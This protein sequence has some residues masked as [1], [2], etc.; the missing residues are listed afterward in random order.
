[1]NNA[2]GDV[3]KT[4][5]SSKCF[6]RIGEDGATYRGCF[7]GFREI[8]QLSYEYNGC[9]N[10]TWNNKALRWCFCDSDL[11]NG[12]SLAEMDTKRGYKEYD[13]N[14]VD[15]YYPEDKQDYDQYYKREEESRYVAPKT[16]NMNKFAKMAPSGSQGEP[17]E[18]VVETNYGFDVAHDIAPPQQYQAVRTPPKQY[19]PEY[20]T[21]YVPEQNSYQQVEETNPY[22]DPRFRERPTFYVEEK[23]PEPGYYQQHYSS[24]YDQQQPETVQGTRYYEEEDRSPPTYY[25]EERRPNHYYTE[26]TRPSINDEGVY[27]QNYAEEPHQY[28]P[29]AREGPENDLFIDENDP[30]YP[31]EPIYAEKNDYDTP[32]AAAQTS[33]NEEESYMPYKTDAPEY[34][35]E[36][37]QDP[38]TEAPSTVT[39]KVQKVSP[40]LASQ[41]SCDKTGYYQNPNDCKQFVAC[42]LD[43]HSKAPIMH[44][45]ECPNGLVW[46]NSKKICM[47]YSTTCESVYYDD[48]PTDTKAKQA[49]SPANYVEEN[50]DQYTDG[51]D[52]KGYQQG[53]AKPDILTYYPDNDS[54]D[55]AYLSNDDFKTYNEDGDKYDSSVYGD[56]YN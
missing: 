35:Y 24:D 29:V 54:Q 1:V 5:C 36:D 32:R 49:G 2:D 55:S 43:P 14:S 16:G 48:Y 51:L 45:M 33:Y 41:I 53:L 34:E 56:E 38:G 18:N 8:G 31:A 7:D 42:L 40:Q 19:Y 50:E 27:K 12:K 10:Q 11:C 26:E 6:A 20:D 4:R 3:F 30:K 46:D 13:Y 17:Y 39:T 37:Y 22:I 28:G 47:E 21:A 44:L 25:E 52:T 23:V 9:Q 15:N